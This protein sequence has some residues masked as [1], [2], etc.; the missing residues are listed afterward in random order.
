MELGQLV[1]DEVALWTFVQGLKM[2]MKREVL[3]EKNLTTLSD[4]I[5]SAERADAVDKFAKFEFK[6]P[7]VRKDDSIVPMD[8]DAMQKGKQPVRGKCGGFGSL[9]GSHSSPGSFG[10]PDQ[11]SRSGFN[12]TLNN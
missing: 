10:G 2:D 7:P 12:G 5:L 1:S 3:R 8:V 11:P 6:G 4:A 9:S